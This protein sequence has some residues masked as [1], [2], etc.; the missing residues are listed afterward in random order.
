MHILDLPCPASALLQETADHV[1]YMATDLYAIN[2]PHFH[3]AE[4]YAFHD[5]YGHNKLRT[6]LFNNLTL[7]ASSNKI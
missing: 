6:P 5:V 1:F 2:N 4:L 3:D 7:K